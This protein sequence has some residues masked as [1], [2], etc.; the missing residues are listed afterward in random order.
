MAEDFRQLARD[1]DE[2]FEGHD[3][4]SG[5][6]GDWFQWVFDLTMG[7]PAEVRPATDRVRKRAA[8]K[9]RT[10]MTL[11]RGKSDEEIGK[12]IIFVASQAEK[13]HKSKKRAHKK[14]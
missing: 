9:I 1:A 13:V 12:S 7:G 2:F 6:R 14:R 8:S 3:S 4:E 10:V 5:P 11:A